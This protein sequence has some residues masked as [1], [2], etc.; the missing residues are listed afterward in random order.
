MKNLNRFFLFIKNWNKPLIF[1]G[2]LLAIVIFFYASGLWRYLTFENLEK[3]RHILKSLVAE[4]Y[5]LSV[6]IYIAVYIAVTAFSIPGAAVL[7]LAGGY[8]Y[9]IFAGA[10]YVN[11]GATA[12]ACAAFLASRYFI[13]ESIQKK[14]EKQLKGFNS[15]IEENGVGY[16]LSLRFI[17]A[18]PFFLINLLAGVTKIGF[19]TFLW[20]TA[21]GIIPGS[22]VYSYA[23]SNLAEVRSASGILSPPIIM[24]FLLLALFSLIPV[25][26][27]RIVQGK[28]K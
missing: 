6:V 9:G 10:F 7:T 26:F 25:F 17:P 23:G 14:F 3:S 16:L 11:I 19:L 27:N 15:E 13:E 2:I 4:H 20:T 18:V 28:K 21:V 5:L 1:I 22:L 24:A 8:L 12:G